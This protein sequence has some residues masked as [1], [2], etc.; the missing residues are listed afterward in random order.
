MEVSPLPGPVK[1]LTL[2][3]HLCMFTSQNRGA[4]GVLLPRCT[5]STEVHFSPTEDCM[6]R[7][8][9]G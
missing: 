5:A 2:T 8:R 9:Q 1:K 4:A 7:R 6:P 3:T